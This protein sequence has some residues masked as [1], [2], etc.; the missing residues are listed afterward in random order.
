MT[1]TDPPALRDLL[2]EV[3]SGALEDASEETWMRVPSPDDAVVD[4]VSI[5]VALADALLADPRIA[6]VALPE[7]ARTSPHGLVA[8][9]W[10]GVTRF[11]DE[12]I[13]VDGL[14]VDLTCAE[15]TGLAA[16]LLA[17][18]KHTRS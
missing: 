1:V 10:P 6:V 14:G 16:A 11:R 18:I 3:L 13:R 2:A 8:A 4:S 15:A 9:E 7:P 12:E 5:P 17:A